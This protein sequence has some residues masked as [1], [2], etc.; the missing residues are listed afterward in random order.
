MCQGHGHQKTKK[1]KKFEVKDIISSMDKL[2]SV[3]RMSIMET[4]E[5]EEI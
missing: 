4:Q 5:E 3:M 1:K 2:G